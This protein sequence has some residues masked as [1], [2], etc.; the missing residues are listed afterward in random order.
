MVSLACAAERRLRHRKHSLLYARLPSRAAED[1]LA[2]QGDVPLHGR[3][4]YE[5]LSV[6]VRASAVQTRTT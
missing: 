2:L 5:G 3:V 4:A 1:D 6:D